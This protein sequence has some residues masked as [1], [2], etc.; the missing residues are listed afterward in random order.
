MRSGKRA[1]LFPPDRLLQLRMALTLVVGF[2]CTVGVFAALVWLWT[3]KP[4]L[5]VFAVLLLLGGWLSARR[6]PLAKGSSCTPP[7][8]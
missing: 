4:F 2:A 7:S 3:A 8:R 6:Q 5:A 1:E